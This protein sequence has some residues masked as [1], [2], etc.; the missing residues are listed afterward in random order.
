MKYAVLIFR[1]CA[2]WLTKNVDANTLVTFLVF[3][4]SIYLQYGDPL[5]GLLCSVQ[6]WN[7]CKSDTVKF[8]SLPILSNTLTPPRLLQEDRF[9][10]Y[11]NELKHALGEYHR[12]VRSI[13]PVMKD[14]LQPHVEVC[15]SV[16]HAQVLLSWPWLVM[17]SNT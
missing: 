8:S 11:Y 13:V 3:L 5:A 14:L 15:V 17:Y 4:H 9:K 6:Q 10:N 1:A 2:N 16:I 12:L 7:C